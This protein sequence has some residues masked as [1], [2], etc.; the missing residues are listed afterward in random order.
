MT[1]Q[2]PNLYLG[3]I[4][5]LWLLPLALPKHCPVALS[6]IFTVSPPAPTAPFLSLNLRKATHLA[7]WKPLR[8]NRILL[9]PHGIASFRC[10]PNARTL[11]RANTLRVQGQYQQE[12]LCP[13]E[14]R[15]A[16]LLETDFPQV[17]TH[18]LHITNASPSLTGLF[19]VACVTLV[20]LRANKWMNECVLAPLCG[21]MCL[22]P[23]SFPGL[24]MH[25]KKKKKSRNRTPTP[26]SPSPAILK[27]R[28]LDIRLLI[29]LR[30]SH[31]ATKSHLKWCKTAW[32]VFTSFSVTLLLF[33]RVEH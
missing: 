13:K 3:R 22:F 16:G 5:Q 21:L 8:V 12:E 33:S 25:A 20:E 29:S 30:Q 23:Y 31:S 24:M 14:K 7:H 11:L 6:S 15:W 26:P 4:C 28:G 27:T 32:T 17:Q 2:F 18:Q 10:S 1:K 19:S 9:R